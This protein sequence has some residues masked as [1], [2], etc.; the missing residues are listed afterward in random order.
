[1]EIISKA[2]FAKFTPDKVRILVSMLKGK[3]PESV[4]PVLEFSNKNAATPI[5]SAIKQGMDQIKSKDLDV[6]DFTIK[7]I[8]SDEGPKLKRRRIRHQGRSTAIL[9]RMSHVTV[10]LTN[11]DAT[12]KRDK[13]KIISDKKEKEPIKPAANKKTPAQIIKAKENKVEKKV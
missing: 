8:M 1:M 9:K 2:K 11:N 12:S 3:K 10:V 13:T 4:L 6:N 5:I 7:T